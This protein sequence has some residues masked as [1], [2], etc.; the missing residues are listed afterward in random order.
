[1]LT[2][3]YVYIMLLTPAA[4]EYSVK[5]YWGNTEYYKNGSSHVPSVYADDVTVHN[6]NP[7]GPRGHSTLPPVVHVDT[8][9]YH[10]DDVTVCNPKS[11]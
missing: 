3:I 10:A 8:Q 7:G 4:M 9:P 2:Y 6:P 1:M 11:G 5:V